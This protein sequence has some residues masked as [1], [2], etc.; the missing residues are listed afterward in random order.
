[1]PNLRRALPLL[2][3]ALLA[4]TGCAEPP[5]E[6]VASA[7]QAGEDSNIEAFAQ[8]FLPASAEFVRNIAAV[9]G[10]N[11]V[12]SYLSQP[13]DV[14]PKGEILEVSERDNLA[15]VT[16]K[17]KGKTY[18]VR[19]LRERGIWFIDAFTLPTLWEPLGRGGES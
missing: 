3:A 11:K 15:V 16:V 4:L 12:G 5:A 19:L 9:K 7:W 13:F 14:L 2:A 6:R 10:R 18:P 8:F 17:A 1:M